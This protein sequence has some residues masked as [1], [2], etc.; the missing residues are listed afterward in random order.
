[1]DFVKVICRAPVVAVLAFCAVTASAQQAP[2][3]SQDPCAQVSASAEEGAERERRGVD[4]GVVDPT[5]AGIEAAATCLAKVGQALIRMIPGLPSF[6][7][8][9]DEE[10]IRMMADRA[11]RVSS[12]TRRVSAVTSQIDRQ[13]REVSGQVTSGTGGIVRQEGTV[14]VELPTTRSTTSTN[15]GAA[16]PQ[17]SGGLWDRISGFFN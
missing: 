7:V 10:I 13:I 3:E 9:S 2:A 12:V 14:R 4:T 6:G 16:S 1:M 8:M 5:T 17:S 15:G 11:C